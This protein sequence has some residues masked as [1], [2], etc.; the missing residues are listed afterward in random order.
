V[1]INQINEDNELKLINEEWKNGNRN[2]DSR[3]VRHREV[4][5]TPEHEA[6]DRIFDSALKE[7]PPF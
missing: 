5:V 6:A 3:K 2:N 7:A 4:N 1:K